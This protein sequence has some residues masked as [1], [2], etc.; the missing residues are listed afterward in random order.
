MNYVAAGLCF[1][2]ALLA[3]CMSASARALRSSRTHPPVVD[4]QP[5]ATKP[6]GI[7]SSVQ[8]S[9]SPRGTAP[10]PPRNG[11]AKAWAKGVRKAA[12]DELEEMAEDMFEEA[13]GVGDSETDG[14]NVSEQG[15]AEAAAGEYGNVGG[16]T[17]SGEGMDGDIG[18]GMTQA[19]TGPFGDF[20]FN[21]GMTPAATGGTGDFQFSP[22]TTQQT[23]WMAHGHG[24]TGGSTMGAGHSG[25]GG[26][27]QGYSDTGGTAQGYSDTGG[28]AQAYNGDMGMQ[29]QGWDMDMMAGF[30]NDMVMMDF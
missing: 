24:D 23:D 11:I 19:D 15:V 22:S 5:Q 4:R 17:T 20:Q 12:R 13:M 26:V 29:T 9:H 18:A 30:D 6:I 25:G 27:A 21:P 14:T 1:F 10:P 16:S 28:M 7:P 8:Q 3:L 2:C